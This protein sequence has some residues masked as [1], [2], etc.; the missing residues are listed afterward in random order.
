MHHTY[1]QSNIVGATVRSTDCEIITSRK[2]RCM[3]CARFHSTLRSCCSRESNATST[4]SE[5]SSH[6]R[7]GALTSEQ[8]EARIQSLHHSLKLSK[9]RVKYLEGKV[10]RLMCN[11]ALE[12][13]DSDCS[14]IVSIISDVQHK[15]EENFAPDSP[16]RILWDQQ[17]KYN[18]LQ[19][20]RQMRWHP[21]VIRY[22]V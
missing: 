21:L 8:K 5:A 14:D 7:Y 6:T 9:L 20:K 22:T 18:R 3:A 12:L 17:M 4:R 15:V 16:Q 11:Q 13:H 19:D 1:L 10:E 2:G